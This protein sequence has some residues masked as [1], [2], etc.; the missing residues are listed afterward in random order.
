MNL[1]Q[2]KEVLKSS[3]HILEEVRTGGDFEVECW[4]QAEKIYEQIKLL[5]ENKEKEHQETLHHGLQTALIFAARYSHDRPTGASLMIT[6][7]LKL[8]WPNLS[9][10][11]KK[12]ILKESESAT[13]NLEDWISLRE[14]SKNK[15]T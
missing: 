12:Q 10:N 3:A 6:N 9:E 5:N 11:V 1:E 8:Y 13:E 14:Y 7:T 4:E 2:L 15:L